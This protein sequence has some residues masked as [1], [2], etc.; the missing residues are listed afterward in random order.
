MAKDASRS[1]RSGRSARPSAGA[2]PQAVA[3]AAAHTHAVAESGS[4]PT[5]IQVVDTPEIYA[6][7]IQG[8]F[9]GNDFVLT[10]AR[11]IPAMA[12]GKLAAVAKPAAVV[13][14]SAQTAKDL[15]LVMTD[16]I[17]QHEKAFGEIQTEFSRQL[18]SSRR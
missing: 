5:D 3:D 10:L 2:S 7:S 14:L 8:F 18:R 1:A 12:D 13:H 16:Q 15:L 9:A 6:S 11:P 4:P 17:E